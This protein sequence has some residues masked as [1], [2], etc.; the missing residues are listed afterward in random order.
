MPSYLFF[1]GTGIR[2]DSAMAMERGT[3]ISLHNVRLYAIAL[4]LSGS[5]TRLLMDAAF[6]VS[7]TKEWV[8]YYRHGYEVP[9]YLHDW[10]KEYIERTKENHDKKS[11]RRDGKKKAAAK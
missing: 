11:I 10:L 3:V 5:Q 7:G 6:S 8:A 2:Y 1:D 9:R 4:G